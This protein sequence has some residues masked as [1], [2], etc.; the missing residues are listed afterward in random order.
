MQL[1]D[2]HAHLDFAQYDADREAMLHRAAVVGVKAILAVGI[3]DG[4]ANMHR[5]LEIA[6]EYAGREDFPKIYASVGI[7]PSEGAFADAAALER[8]AALA[9]NQNCIAIGEIGL[10]YY[11]AENPPIATQHRVF[12]EQMA[13]AA[14]ARLPILIHCRASDGAA[15]EASAKFGAADA[16]E[17]TLS[18]IAAHW[19]PTG[20]GGVMHCFSGTKEIAR[21]SMDM[22][23]LISFVGNITYPKAQA[24]R[25]AAAFVPIS[26]ILIETDAP[27]LAPVPHRGQR[28]EPAFVAEVARQLAAIHSTDADSIGAATTENFH[29]L[30]GTG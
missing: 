2:S 7:H 30:F 3:G 13:I 11:H 10:D 14:A 19:R 23:F 5:A 12:I 26:N 17:D 25:D 29:R 20:L 8:V 6:A 22:G 9:Q 21:R 18:L 28:N 24:I 16:W 15:P 1:I 27:F 4:P